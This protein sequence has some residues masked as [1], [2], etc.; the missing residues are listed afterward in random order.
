MAIDRFTT[1]QFQAAL[2]VGAWKALGIIQ[3]EHCYLVIP[4][5]APKGYG[6]LVRS[7]IGASGIA[8]D[9]GEDSIRCILCKIDGENVKPIGNKAKRWITRVNGWQG[10]M[11][12][13]LRHCKAQ[14]SRIRSCPNGCAAHL[15]PFTSHK[16]ESKGRAFVSCQVPGC[17]FFE[18]CD[19]PIKQATPAP[20][21]TAVAS[22]PPCPK[23]N[24]AMVR[25]SS[26]K[27]AR[28]ATPGNRWENGAWSKC[29]GVIWDNVKPVAQAPALTDTENNLRRLL[30]E[31]GAL[32]GKIT[33]TEKTVVA[34]VDKIDGT[35][36][37]AL[38]DFL[39]NVGNA[40]AER[41][42][43]PVKA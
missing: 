15:V 36:A 27:G 5:D 42:S 22:C 2:P 43:R 37:A 30:S 21:Q 33:D 8:D 23:C 25:M 7:S 12:E 3:G 34:L 9:C 13:T 20:A 17:K 29:D 19:E 1:E 38:V 35:E 41:A 11:M 32:L 6:V 18:W 10:R 24:S 28:C 4:S 40:Q 14:L 26:G 31:V 39:I 16:K